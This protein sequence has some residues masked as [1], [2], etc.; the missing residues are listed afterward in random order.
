MWTLSL[1][2]ILLPLTQ[3]SVL[4]GTTGFQLEIYKQRNHVLLELLVNEGCKVLPTH[5]R[6]VRAIEPLEIQLEAEK[7]LYG[8]LTDQ[9]ITCRAAK[10]KR[11]RPTESTSTFSIPTT[12]PTTTTPTTT[13][14]TTTTPT[15]TS[16]APCQDRNMTVYVTSD[17]ER[18]LVELTPD[19][20]YELPIGRSV[21]YKA[22]CT[23]NVNVM[24][25]G[26]FVST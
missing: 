21:L 1:L 24:K 26:G 7:V 12:T 18:V 6:N 15:T 13:T 25:N 19:D 23:I 20:R 5:E 16:R 3:A 8:D 2:L 4:H 11:T 17:D 22:G 9:L 10:S 14:P